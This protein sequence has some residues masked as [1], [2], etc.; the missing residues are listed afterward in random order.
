MIRDHVYRPPNHAKFRKSKLPEPPCEFMNCGRS[1]AEHERAVS[2]RFGPA[3]A[4]AR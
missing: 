4:G 1:R 2:G 3:K